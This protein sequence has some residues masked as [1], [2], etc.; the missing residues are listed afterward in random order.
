MSRPRPGRG[1]HA[2]Q[3]GR[4][5]PLPSPSP[6]PRRAG[7]RV[8]AL[9]AIQ[10]AWLMMVLVA[11]VAVFSPVV[12]AE[13]I[14]YDDDIYVTENPYVQ[15]LDPASV[16]ALFTSRYQNQYAPVAML[17][18]A[19]EFQ[20]FHGNA[21]ALRWVSVL[22]HLAN[23]LLLF[24]LVR[25]LFGRFPVALITAALF[26][27]HPLQVESVAWITAHMKIGWFVLFGLASLLAYLSWAQS[28]QAWRWA[29]SLVLFALSCLCKEQA[30][31]LVG[32]LPMIDYALGRDLRRR[33][34]WLEKLPFV[35]V[36]LVIGAATLR[37]AGGQQSQAMLVVF[38]LADRVVLAAYAFASYLGQLVAPIRLSAFHVYPVRVPP[39]YALSLV[40]V[41]AALALLIYA[42][43]RGQRLVVFAIAFFLTHLA[44]TVANQ[45]FGLRDVLMAD[46]YLYMPSVGAFLL[47]A[48]GWDRLAGRL[49]GMRLT[50]AV[51]LVALLSGC[52]VASYRRAGV[53]HDS[54][55]LFTDVIEK[56]VAT[57][58]RDN[59][60]LALPYN[61]RGVA[62]K[63]RGDIE[64]G[65][66]DFNEATRINSADSRSHVNRANVYFNRGEYARALPDYDRAIVLDP[67]NA[68][69]YSNRGG[70]HANSG[71]FDLALADF[72]KAL[73]IQPDFLDALR[74]R[75]MVHQVQ[76]R[77][78]QALADF[79]HFLRLRPQADV[80]DMRG[81]SDQGLGRLREAEADFGA[82]IRLDP[83]NGTALVNRSRLRLQA[84]DRAGALE[85]AL[86]AQ[87][88]G[89]TLAPGYLESLR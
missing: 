16:R 19:A 44:L 68:I 59:P 12:R 1:G 4:R 54:L 20:L 38:S 55:T 32:T 50:L 6:T 3:G 51:G 67:R 34:L 23:V 69:A 63:N 27:L 10:W 28:R 11:T 89:V 76:G 43:R 42:W 2:P 13:Y 73:E 14:N 8:S 77:H 39:A 62:R 81:L 70:V 66:A 60:F 41:A 88:L 74:N 24:V 82:A 48:H 71:R 15:R 47:V 80:Y 36:A 29:V 61:N 40:A 84:G 17:L 37:S 57:R 87:R 58:G 5:A 45:V 83:R 22:V 25:R 49:P 52:A 33:R 86:T 31:A 53:W 9:S 72:G 18:M 30:V 35:A 56:E 85:D 26:A 7:V 79:D 75:G 46:R 65:L 78:E 64:G 21:A